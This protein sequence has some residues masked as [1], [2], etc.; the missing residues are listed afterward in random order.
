MAQENIWFHKNDDEPYDM[1]DLYWDG[2]RVLDIKI[3]TIIMIMM[4]RK[5]Y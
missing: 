3:L 5:Y 2:I 1:I 4:L